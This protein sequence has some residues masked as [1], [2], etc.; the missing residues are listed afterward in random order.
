M[1]SRIPVIL[2]L[3]VVFCS[4]ATFAQTTSGSIAGTVTDSQQAAIHKASV[5]VTD[6]AK[7]FSQTT[8]TDSEGRF[9]FPEL[10][11]STYTIVVEAGGFK[12]LQKTG[13][14]LVANDKLA[15]GDMALEVG[16]TSEVVTVVAA[17][18]Q[19]QAESAERSYAVQGE[20]L[21]NIAVNGRGFTPLASIAPGIVFQGVNTGSNDNLSSISANGQR[22][23]D[24][25]LQLD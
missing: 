9:V 10:S 25:G 12:K 13:I 6:E 11:P 2:V 8:T 18:T 16:A 19:I 23:N 5:T 21:R 3:I 4:Q 24:N 22:L 17:A 20:A 14:S 7:G 15:L 1:R